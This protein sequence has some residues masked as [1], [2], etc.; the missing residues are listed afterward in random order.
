MEKIKKQLEFLIEI[1]KIKGILRQTLILGGERRENDAEHS[2][3]MALTAMTV[4]EYF[5]EKVDMEKVLKMILLHDIVEI[6]AGDTPC[7]GIGNPNKY[8]E[9]KASAQKIFSYL[10]K[11]QSDEF[12]SIWEEFEELKTPEAK[13]SN[14]CDRLQGFIQNITS[15]GHTW[16]K[17][18]VTREKVENR[19]KPI[20]EFAPEIYKNFVLPEIEKYIERGIIN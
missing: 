11:E 18:N 6:Y 20:R 17:Y 7:F 13:F 4:R 3:H 2:W 5:V 10:P 14:L 1:D 12:M 8:E 16:K 15:D 9:E 19:V